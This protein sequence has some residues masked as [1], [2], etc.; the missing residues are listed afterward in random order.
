MEEEE[1]GG[2]VMVKA[3]AIVHDS[4]RPGIIYL[5]LHRIILGTRTVMIPDRPGLA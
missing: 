4:H 1:G 2:E 3:T 5:R